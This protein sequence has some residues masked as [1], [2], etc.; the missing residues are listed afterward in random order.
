MANIDNPSAPGHRCLRCRARPKPILHQNKRPRPD[1]MLALPP[2]DRR[3]EVQRPPQTLL[4]WK[5]EPG[6][7]STGAAYAPHLDAASDARTGAGA[8]LAL[9]MARAAQRETL[10][11]LVLVAAVKDGG[12]PEH[13]LR[14]GALSALL[15]EALQQPQTW[16]DMLFD[17]APLHDL[18]KATL[19]EALLNKSGPLLPH[20]WAQVR[21]HP[22]VGAYVLGDSDN[23][24]QQ[25]AAEI[26]LNHHEKWDGSGY[27]AHRSAHQIPLSGRIVAVADFFDSVTN[28]SCY[29]DAMDDDA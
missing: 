9:T 16:C 23:P 6:T 15:A 2:H 3:L 19:P 28:A 18:G 8:K 25:L 22:V 4:L 1:L 27:P 10:R 5:E 13:C 12:T 29:R 14:V 21:T 26:A 7:P 20:E 11:R 24:V 17:A